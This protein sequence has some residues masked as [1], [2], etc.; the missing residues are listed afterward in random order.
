[1]CEILSETRDR[2]VKI[3]NNR[4]R[5]QQEMGDTGMNVF[6]KRRRTSLMNHDDGNWYHAF[7]KSVS[8]AG[9]R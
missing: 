7:V 4:K 5:D 2:V 1:M 9:L 8:F 3:Q 6:N